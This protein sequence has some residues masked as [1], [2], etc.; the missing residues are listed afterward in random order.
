[1]ELP[2]PPPPPP[3]P[4]LPSSVAQN[5]GLSLKSGPLWFP[6]F[7]PIFSAAQAKSFDS[8]FLYTHIGLFAASGS[9]SPSTNLFRALTPGSPATPIWRP[10]LA[11]LFSLTPLQCVV[12]PPHRQAQG[13]TTSPLPSL[14]IQEADSPIAWQGHIRFCYLSVPH[15][16]SGFSGPKSFSSPRPSWFFQ[17][18]SYSCFCSQVKPAFLGWGGGRWPFVRRVAW[19]VSKGGGR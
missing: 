1:M 15:C 4:N 6:L 7:C 14:P 11:S 2:T 10:I 18:I 19:V 12:S 8:A 3:P 16:S 5:S 17:A 13:L 9:D